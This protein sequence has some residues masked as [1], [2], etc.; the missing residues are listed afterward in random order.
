MP[1][2][3]INS[4]QTVTLQPLEF[5]GSFFEALPDFRKLGP[6]ATV[7]VPQK[8][9][10]AHAPISSARFVTAIRDRLNRYRTQD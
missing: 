8:T 10:E 5:C 7:Q 2:A 4:P 3:S 9:G 1:N 6:S